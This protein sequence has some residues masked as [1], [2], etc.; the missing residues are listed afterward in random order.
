MSL[1]FKKLSRTKGGGVVE[2]MNEVV[3]FGF[4]KV[5]QNKVS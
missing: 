1:G 2:K 4:Q 5:E 3:M